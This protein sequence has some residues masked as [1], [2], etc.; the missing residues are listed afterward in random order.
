M[1]D[2]YPAS[3][4]ARKEE[5]RPGIWFFAIFAAAVVLSTLA[6]LHGG[7]NGTAVYW[8]AAVLSVAL[9]IFVPTGLLAMLWWGVR[10]FERDRAEGPFAAWLIMVGIIGTMAYQGALL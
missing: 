3:G 7:G 5:P 2:L 4:D 1:D 10:K 8:F 6:N 9:G